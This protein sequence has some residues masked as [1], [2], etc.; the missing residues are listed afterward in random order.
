MNNTTNA[1]LR[2]TKCMTADINP[3]KSRVL[4]ICACLFASVL[5][6]APTIGRASPLSLATSPLFLSTP[7]Q[8]NVMLLIDDSG[9]MD[10][11]IWADGYD[12]TV[13]YTHWGS[14]DWSASNGN[15]FHSDI[16]QGS[17]PANWQQG[18]DGTTTKC[19][20]LPDPIG[21]GGTRYSGNYLNYLFSTYPN[22]TDLTTGPIG[23]I[24]VTSGGSGY[25]STPTVTI[26]GGGG[27]GATATATVVAGQVTSVTITNGGTGY[28]STP[29]VVFSGGGGT[30]AAATASGTIPNDIRMNVA[31]EV[32]SDLVTT[33]TGVRFGVASLGTSSNNNQGAQVH[34]TCG[35]STST[36]TT[37]INALASS[38]WTPLG[39]A[40]YEVTRYFRGLT[41]YYNSSVSYTSP[42]QYRCQKNFVVVI[43]D[44]YPT[45]D[46]SFPTTDPSDT[47]DTTAALPNWDGLA[48]ATAY[49]D[50]PASMPQYS[51]GFKPTN[52]QS[53]EAYSLYLD[54]IAKFAYD[55]DL[56]TSPAT[57]A[58]GTDFDH[59]EF[60][61]QNIETYTVGFAVENQ[62][63]EDAASYGHGLYYTANSAAQLTSALKSALNDIQGKT[64]TAAAV[65]VNSRSLNTNT[66]VY[67]ALFASGE[68]SG[69]LKAFAIDN[70]TGNIG[71]LAW[72]A[73]AQ[74]A[75]QSWDTGTNSRQ[76][77]TR[78]DTQGI[79]FRW[80]TSGATTLTGRQQAALNTDPTTNTQDS[81]SQGQARLNYLR[82][83]DTNEG[84]YRLRGATGSKFK[85]GDIVNSSPFYVGVPG[86]L[87]ESLADVS[88]NSFRTTHANRT[89]MIYVGANDGMLHGFAADSGV[90]KIAYVPTGVFYDAA[91]GLAK[92]NQLTNPA[93][94]HRFFVDGSPTVNDV[95][96][97]FTN[98]GS[99]CTTTVGGT[100]VAGCW[101]TVLASG[102]GAGG[103]GVF[104]LDVT[105]PSTFSESNAS[106]I[107]LW[108]FRDSTAISAIT[109]TAGGSGYTS[110]PTVT[111]SGGGGS[112]ATAVATITGGVVTS[113]A[114]TAGGSG[115][116]SA[117]TVTISGGGGTG[118]TATAGLDIGND[119]GYTYS[120][121][122]I[123]KMKDGSWAVIFGNGYNS[124]NER[125]VLYIVN[126]VTGQLTT[127]IVL[128]SA[129]GGGNGLST[130]AVVD[131]DGD[132]V[133]DYIF[134][135][136]LK[137]NM[138]K[139]DVSATN[140]SSWD[141]FYK[142][143]STLKP[144]FK[145]TDGKGVAQPITERPEIG[146]QPT[147]QG[148]YMVYFGTGRYL[149]SDDNVARGNLSITLTSG[150]GGYTSAPTVTISGGGGSG[151][152]AT[153]TVFGGTVTAVTVTNS[154]SGYT[155]NP[156]VSFSGGGGSG[157]SAT[158]SRHPTHT[159]Y[160]VWDR[161]TTTSKT[162]GSSATA[163]VSRARLLPQTIGTTTVA[164]Q[165]VRSV[166]DDVIG[167]WDDSGAACAAGGRCMGWRD[168]LP[169]DD[170]DV[171]STGD[172]SDSLGEM[173]VSNPVLLG[174]GLP[175]IIFTTL[176]PNNIACSFGGSSWLMELNPANGGRLPE[177][178]F[179]TDGDGAIDDDDKIAGTP[180]QPTAGM[181]STIGI[182][183]EPI[184][185]RD[186]DNGRDLKIVAGSAGTIQSIK[187]YVSKQSGGRQSWR[188]LR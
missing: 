175:R 22:S 188:Q 115:Y 102:L 84:T 27:T 118:A 135:G 80:T 162:V 31:R 116:T 122:S 65:A 20:K 59:P 157:A 35:S 149:A 164:G 89:E 25:T 48:P 47:A 145:A 147:G 46:T 86:Y 17:C 142:S 57:D 151:A 156:T 134:A 178:V 171:E 182:M 63:L 73:K 21:G 66:R 98:T 64:S 19:L 78:N 50:F 185:V 100:S 5:I 105:D 166:T 16:N 37:E 140:S 44:G 104:A 121:P 176:I 111:I 138:W 52:D 72:S 187:N 56:R 148:G 177:Q 41:G 55:I 23:S 1:M 153:A 82:G 36:L 103:K 109:V 131:K 69:D 110:A 11:I 4:E 158:T 106:Q 172:Y 125:P 184:I 75:A 168:D 123:A 7:V 39:E 77:I 70:S 96:G 112:G 144:L 28:T 152:A 136:D 90:E 26:S 67:Q 150:G 174:G 24:T 76:I 42:V 93:Y 13:S 155:S 30:G 6:I 10:N 71:A 127:K 126:A 141:S 91:T 169:T 43:T 34:A 53:Y 143:G 183:P 95:F 137:G 128:D 163:A 107:S 154:G 165:E 88:H 124:V 68:W 170:T 132:Y 101:R 2:R 173:S 94:S 129:T 120:Q 113:I 186:P 167:T 29:T 130:P 49:A 61:K 181:K 92:I 74:V 119:M 85:L 3:W 14:T 99:A 108:E 33:T 146:D 32:A 97:S 62:M 18:S 12:N 117:P 160:G 159:F 139:I 45:Y 79:P 15:F 9:S 51:D 83:D 180:P 8:P 40:L 161:D 81:P 60:P 87:P 38:T 179:D 133:A 58:T 54:D 114:V